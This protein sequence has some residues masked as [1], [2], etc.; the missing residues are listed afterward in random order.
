MRNNEIY[1]HPRHFIYF[2]SGLI[3]GISVKYFIRKVLLSSDRFFSTPDDP[4]DLALYFMMAVGIFTGLFIDDYAR[5]HE[6]EIDYR[7]FLFF[8]RLILI[9]LNAVFVLLFILTYAYKI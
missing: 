7:N 3:G 8:E 6:F 9:F 1:L 5:C 2:G 4:S